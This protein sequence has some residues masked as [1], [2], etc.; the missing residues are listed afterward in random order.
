MVNT[1]V[2]NVQLRLEVLLGDSAR[3]VATFADN[4]RNT[5]PP[6]NQQWFIAKINSGAIGL[7]HQHAPSLT[8]VS[9]GENVKLNAP[10]LQQFAKRNHK[11]SLPRTAH[12]KIPHADHRPLQPPRREHAAIEHSVPQSGDHTVKSG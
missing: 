12:R 9:A 5:Q 2:E 11:R 4:H 3:S 6:R 8:T 10:R 1:I 7:N